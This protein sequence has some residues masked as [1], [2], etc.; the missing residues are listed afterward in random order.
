MPLTAISDD[1]KDLLDHHE[2]R[3]KGDYRT[4]KLFVDSA[5]RDKL[6]KEYRIDA[7]QDEIIAHLEKLETSK[8]RHLEK[9]QVKKLKA[10]HKLRLA[11][12]KRK[13]DSIT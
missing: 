9:Q 8:S 2:E 6:R 5:V 13:L 1:L 3:I 10:R 4:I 12:A 11:R 7:G